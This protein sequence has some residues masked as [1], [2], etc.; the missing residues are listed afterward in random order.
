MAITII[1]AC[2]EKVK[3]FIQKKL[4]FLAAYF[5]KISGTAAVCSAACFYAYNYSDSRE[6][7]R[8]S[9]ISAKMANSSLE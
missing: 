3:H 4:T 6:S 5:S 7:A 1:I 8:V 2:I 9:S